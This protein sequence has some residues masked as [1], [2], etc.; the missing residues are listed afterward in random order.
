MMQS[1]IG[2]A[3]HSMEQ[4][5]EVKGRAAIPGL[6]MVYTHTP[7]YTVDVSDWCDVRNNCVCVR[8]AHLSEDRHSAVSCI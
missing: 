5:I 7:I 1:L 3:A 8:V 2:D 6:D 4:S